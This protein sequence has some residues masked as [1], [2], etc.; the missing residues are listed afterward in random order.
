M[1]DFNAS[2]AF[3]GVN[4]SELVELTESAGLVSAYHFHFKDEPFGKEKRPTHFHRGKES[5]AFHLDYIFVPRDWAIRI[6]SVTVGD[7]SSRHKVSD[8]APLIVDLAL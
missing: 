4:W 7:Y 6:T 3:T 5:A 1:G 2:A 8:H